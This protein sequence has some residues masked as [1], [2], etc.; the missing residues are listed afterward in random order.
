MLPA[1]Q[2]TAGIYRPNA[3]KANQLY[4]SRW[5]GVLKMFGVRSLRGINRTDTAI[6]PPHTK[7]GGVGRRIG[8][9]RRTF[10]SAMVEIFG[11]TGI[12]KIWRSV[13]FGMPS[14]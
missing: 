9:V 12:L 10:G 8:G 3:G 7:C 14:G 6:R 4:V 11:R 2:V 1:A 13:A 5:M